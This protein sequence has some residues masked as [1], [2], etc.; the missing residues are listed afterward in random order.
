MAQRAQN[1]GNHSRY[2]PLY[3]FL[4]A[5]LIVANLYRT[6]RALFA[7][8]NEDRVTNFLVAII[9]ALT[10]WFAR[11]FALAAQDRVIRLEMRLRLEKLLTPPM[12]GRFE[13]LRPGQLAALRFASDS[14]LP[15]LVGDVLDSGLVRPAEI[16]QRVRDWQADWLRV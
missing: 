8:F 6:G 16:K 1:F 9:L 14:E 13:E 5:G 11:A 3:H 15:A 7:G 4:L 2:V 10:A 12:F